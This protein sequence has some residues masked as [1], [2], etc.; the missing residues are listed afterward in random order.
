[1]INMSLVASILA[2]ASFEVDDAVKYILEPA[3]DLYF[4]GVDDESPLSDAQY[5]YIKRLV[6]SLAPFHQFFTGV[7]ASV[8]GGKIQLPFQMGSLDQ[9]EV[10]DLK[11]WV[12]TNKLK[13]TDQL[14]LMAKLDG[15]SGAALLNQHDASLRIAYSRGNGI[16][17]ADI[18]RH[19]K[20]TIKLQKQQLPDRDPA[21]RGE[22]IITKHNFDRH[23]QPNFK[24]ADGKPY[25]NPRNAVSG[26]MNASENDPRVYEYIDF[27]AYQS[28]GARAEQLDKEDQLLEL[29]EIGFKVPWYDV[30]S[31]KD[32]TEDYLA[33]V[34][35]KLRDDYEYEI[36]GLVVEVNDAAL[37]RQLNPEALNPGY[38]M[39]YKVPGADNIAQTEVVEV[40]WNA[41]KTSYGKPRVIVK[42]ASLPGITWT[43]A[44]GYNAKWIVDNGI[45]PG[46]IV[47]GQRMGDVVP[48]I[49]RVVKSVEP[50]MPEGPYR[51]NETGVDIILE[52][53]AVLDRVLTMQLTETARSL[54]IDYLREGNAEKIVK[55]GGYETFNEMFAAIAAWPRKW[56]VDLIG[57][58]GGKIYDDFHLKLSNVP[59]S[60]WLGSMPHFGRGVGRRKMKALCE[61]LGITNLD[62]FNAIN[63]D[64]IVTVEGFKDKTAFKIMAGMASH[65]ELFEKI[66]TIIKF[67]Q[68]V[69]VG[70]RFAGQKVV[71][72]GFRDGALEKMIE[73]EGGEMQT[74]V[75]A[76]TTLVIA[77]SISGSSG[78]LKKVHD[79]NNSGKASIK[80]MDLATFRKEYIEQQPLGVEF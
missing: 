63:R 31:V 1:M 75:S 12:S 59:L 50:Q 32:V 49:I 73:A 33:S 72:T 52:G 36:D 45:G 60:V 23:V 62:Q 51:W 78:K 54:D 9:V 13:P 20:H 5:D 68:K 76:K 57:D 24:R 8:R 56:W 29:E 30:V 15:S 34:I 64:L 25:A 35:E 16:E 19:L 37:R 27:V 3:S 61:G 58:V 22:N 17:G 53:D 65:A 55:A 4:N 70:K 74:G 66:S 18:T 10:G 40:E 71:I 48:N 43:Y 39:K 26:M 77:A 80:L 69:A 21:F 2:G 42:A 14:V 6:Q 67:Q 46:A 28:I 38:A 79:L 11:K 41:S 7:G 44:T 47:V